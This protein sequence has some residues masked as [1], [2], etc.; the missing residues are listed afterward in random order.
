LGD[1]IEKNEMG[2]ACDTYGGEERCIQGFGGEILCEVTTW[3]KLAWVIS[4]TKTG[5]EETD[6]ITLAQAKDRWQV[7]LNRVVNLMWVFTDFSILLVAF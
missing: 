7:L 3:N 6:W 1:Q 4:N 5:P 2:E